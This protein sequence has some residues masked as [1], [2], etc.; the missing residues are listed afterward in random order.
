MYFL[1]QIQTKLIHFIEIQINMSLFLISYGR[2]IDILYITNTNRRVFDFK[3]KFL[4]LYKHI[5]NL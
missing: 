5:A 3:K 2:P 1:F 4:S